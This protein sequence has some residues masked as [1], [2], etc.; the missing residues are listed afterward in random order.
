MADVILYGKVETSLSFA[1]SKDKENLTKLVAK[2]IG[3]AK[4]D[5]LHS[6]RMALRYLVNKKHSGVVNKLFTELKEKYQER[7]GG[8]TRITKLG[9][10]KGD[11]DLRVIFSLV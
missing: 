1:K 11:N 6:R 5:T 9:L 2:L 10:R 8:Y 7:K 4:Q 3:Y